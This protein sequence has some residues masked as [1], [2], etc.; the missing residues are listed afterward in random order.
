M[1]NALEKTLKNARLRF[2]RSPIAEFFGWWKDELLGC[3]PKSW[4]DQL[5]T[6]AAKVLLA[7]DAEGWHAARVRGDKVELTNRVDLTDPAAVRRVL[8]KLETH[9]DHPAE[10][11]VLCLSANQ[12]LR[13]RLS[14]PLAAEEN[15]AQ[16]LAFEM[17][18]Q[19]PF[20]AAQVYFDWKI[21]KRDQAQRQLLIDLTLVPKPVLDQALEAAKPAQ[22]EFDGV[23]AM[24]AR[25]QV[26]F[27][28]LLGVNLLPEAKRSASADSGARI[29]WILTAGL[30]G[31]IGVI[32]MQSLQARRDAL[33]AL[34][35]RTANVQKK[36]MEAA[37]LAKEV[38]SAIAAANFLVERKQK[39]PE[40]V[41][42]L[43]ELT[44][45]IPDDTFLERV[46]F[47][48]K[49]VQIMGQSRSADKLIAVLQKSKYMQNPQFQGV[50][51]P[52]PSSGRE[53]FNLQIDLREESMEAPA[54]IVAPQPA[55]V[56]NGG[57]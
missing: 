46:T 19:T 4:R 20:T 39:H 17:D 27:D 49:A 6:P 9:N 29:R 35:E 47:V 40:T 11:R 30:L 53:R 10:Q 44:Q 52:D 1:A 37:D 13:K 45:L 32:M 43:L 33:T 26:K 25:D 22:L 16:V 24:V 31:L 50:R 3:L 23:D 48:G 12:V 51:Q 57:R 55:L 54:P 42:V 34:E 38:R 2:A 56:A 18:R 36:A 5:S 28:A 14:L 8:H 41:K 21:V 7:S 15:L